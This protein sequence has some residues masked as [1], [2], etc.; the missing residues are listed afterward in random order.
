MSIR[1]ELIVFFLI[2]S[3]IPL[4]AVV[5]I[6]YEYSKEAIRDSV[7]DN[8]RGATEDTGHAIDNWMAARNTE[9]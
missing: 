8:L 7:I 5:Y 3:V 2:I 4:S 1:S 6:S 9:T